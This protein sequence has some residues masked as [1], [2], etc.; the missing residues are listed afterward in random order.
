MD[1]VDVS[2]T[3][4]RCPGHSYIVWPVPETLLL[5][6]DLRGRRPT[7]H[8]CRECSA[9]QS[10][11]ST[12]CRSAGR[13][14]ASHRPLGVRAALASMERHSDDQC[15]PGI[16]RVHD[17]ACPAVN[18]PQEASYP[19]GHAHARSPNHIL[20][21]VKHR[22]NRASSAWL[23]RCVPQDFILIF[24]HFPCMSYGKITTAQAGVCCWQRNHHAQIISIRSSSLKTVGFCYQ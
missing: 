16:G 23:R 5:R 7:T 19:P 21:K 15:Q 10:A 20:T 18:S 6:I 11:P 14:D 9:E 24:H 12:G 1:I 13:N 8:N 2:G 22:L 4:K 3:G 17:A